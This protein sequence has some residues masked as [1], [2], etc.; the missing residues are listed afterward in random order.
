MALDLNSLPEDPDEIKGGIDLSSLPDEPVAGGIDINALPDEPEV[1]LDA[2]PDEPA[3]APATP[4]VEDK[5]AVSPLSGL[6]LIGDYAGKA[7]DAV[8]DN[9][10]TRWMAGMQQEALNDPDRAGIAG[11]ILSPLAVLG[12]G[13]TPIAES[14][15][16]NRAKAAREGIDYKPQGPVDPLVAEKI[17]GA[18]GRV[19]LSGG[20]APIVEGVAKGL[21][22]AQHEPEEDLTSLKT[23]GR[24]GLA[25]AMTYLPMK[26][27]A[28]AEKLVAKAGLGKVGSFMANAGADLAIGTGAGMAQNIGE[29]ALTGQEITA[30]DF[31]PSAMDVALGLPGTVAAGYGGVRASAA[32][33]AAQNGSNAQIEATP[34]PSQDE[35][36]RAFADANKQ[37][38]AIIDVK[39][40]PEQIAKN[41]ARLEAEELPKVYML[42]GERVETA[43]YRRMKAESEA[44]PV[45]DIASPIKEAYE[46][47]AA[48]RPQ[49]PA[50]AENEARSIALQAKVSGEPQIAKA[51]NDALDGKPTTPEQRQMLRGLGISPL[52]IRQNTLQKGATD[53]LQ[54]REVQGETA[55]GPRI[56]QESQEIAATPEPQAGTGVINLAG[57][58]AP[59]LGLSA[60]SRTRGAVNIDP[61]QARPY[62]KGKLSFETPDGLTAAKLANRGAKMRD[63]E[64]NMP[65]RVSGINIEKFA[66]NDIGS[67]NIMAGMADLDADAINK[68]RGE[69][70]DVLTR[71]AK[72]DKWKDLKKVEEL[73]TNEVLN[74]ENTV[75]LDNFT[76]GAVKRY[77]ENP[78][79]E[80]RE[81][82]QKYLKAS[83]GVGSAEGRAFGA[84]AIARR[85][86][87]RDA[88]P[89]D[90]AIVNTHQMFTEGGVD[91]TPDWVFDRFEKIK[92]PK[93]RTQILQALEDIKRKHEGMGGWWSRYRYF[94][95]LSA[96]KTQAINAS[97][98]ITEAV[99]KVGLKEPI[100]HGI[101]LVAPGEKAYRPGQ[102]TAT[103]A[104]ALH[105]AKQGAE[106]ALFVLGHGGQRMRNAKELDPAKIRPGFR[107][108]SKN[109]ANWPM[110]GLATVDEAISAIGEGAARYSMGYKKAYDEAV[111]LGLS[112]ESLKSYVG[113]HAPLFAEAD[114][115]IAEAALEVGKRLVHQE[116]PW[117]ERLKASRSAPKGYQQAINDTFNFIMPF[118]DIVLNMQAKGMKAAGLGFVTGTLPKKTPWLGKYVKDRTREQALEDVATAAIG[119]S[120]AI[121][122]A[123]M[124]KEGMLTAGVP[125]DAGERELFYNSGKKPYSIKV[126]DSWF[127]YRFL[128]TLAFPLM[129]GANYGD[130]AIKQ[131]QGKLEGTKLGH[132]A[133]KTAK[134]FIDL[135]I[136]ASISG[137]VDAIK[138]PKRGRAFLANLAT[139]FVPAASLQRE[140]NRT[141]ITDGTVPEA[142]TIGERI[143]AS[144]VFDNSGFPMLGL[145]P[146][147]PKR[148]SLGKVVQR[149]SK[150]DPVFVEMDRLGVKPLQ[151]VTSTKLNGKPYTLTSEER[152]QV[153]ASM[154]PIHDQLSEMIQSDTYKELPK[155]QQKALFDA[156]LRTQAEDQ[157]SATNLRKLG[158]SRLR[159][160]KQTGG[161]SAQQNSGK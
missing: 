68:Q 54:P 137:I 43:G 151:P 34:L 91:K 152:S 111:K 97:S 78:T 21:D 87:Q 55:S 150:A 39:G 13:D 28:G 118:W 81:I 16:E 108:G 132:A 9:P 105:G 121:W 84:R 160:S 48:Q 20:A 52:S 80:N 56:N 40:T 86:W 123:S 69:F 139:Q 133:W 127:D 144:T 89:I 75:S 131:S 124:A 60:L 46:T 33:K 93:D 158:L 94:N 71:A 5:P 45:E 30:G 161:N 114:T 138:D 85:N 3:P 57:G 157:P 6:G 61:T 37:Q 72:I 103:Y 106:R 50:Q 128:G 23:A 104:G 63:E 99:Q 116:T 74:D 82:M 2:L 126:G 90:V 42:N 156:M 62:I 65:K 98:N 25:S 107:G 47:G 115:K 36:A 26:A 1:S 100:M 41:R 31:I 112:G 35:M 125:E 29:K 88:E 15:Y 17:G 136:L 7:L 38:P 8:V 129:A 141:G 146:L 122:A 59:T 66:P 19:M 83:A 64:G 4:A 73:K 67:Q 18:V 32:R 113:E 53:G 135:P 95:M 154:E 92:N 159:L 77:G 11:A 10:A 70:K 130:A 109:P 148:N 110:M 145:Q 14:E 49:D 155:E 27:G 24:V 153:Q 134:S 140:L 51:I 76:Y 117:M 119:V 149:D 58:Q 79:K 143:Q 96:L 12:I 101:D 22:I 147:A 120:A 142:N 44:Q 102:L